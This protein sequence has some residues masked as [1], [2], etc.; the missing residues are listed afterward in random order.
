MGPRVACWDDLWRIVRREAED[1]PSW[2]S[3]AA[4]RGVFHEAIRQVREAG[5]IVAIERVVHWPGYRRRL[6]ERIRLWT[7]AE[8]PAKARARGSQRTAPVES[9]EWAVFVRYR[10]L[11]DRLKAED[12]AGMAVWA[13]KRLIRSPR[14]WEAPD[15]TA[16]VVFLDFERS[17][18][19]YWRV[20]ERALAS[21]RPVH[22]TL[23][24]ESDPAGAEVYCATEPIRERLI[25]LGL[26][27]TT[28]GPPAG[29]PAGL[30][31]VEQAL[32]RHRGEGEGESKG[33]RASTVS[34]AQGLAILGGPQGDGVSRLVAREVRALRRRGV[35]PE[36]ILVL[37]RHWSDEADL[38]LETL[39]AW[40]M[41]AHADTPRRLHAEPA[42][43]ALWLAV[44][45]PIE[46][47]ET[48]LIVRLLRHGQFCPGWPGTDRRTLATAASAIRATRVFR[49]REQ[50]LHGLDRA[51]NHAE[52]EKDEIQCERLRTARAVVDRLFTALL[53]LDEPRPWRLQVAEL[54][55]VSRA[56]G[57]GAGDE[58]ALDPLWD[59]LDDAADIWEKLGR[60]QVPWTWADFV[61]EVDAMAREV[62]VPALAPDPGSIPLATVDQAAGACAEY[63][64][65]ADL[66]EGTFPA[67]EEVE[68]FLALGPSDEPDRTT[69]LAF[70][71]EM[72]RFLRAVGSAGAVLTL[73]YPTTDLKG[74]E[75][76]RAGFLE[77]VLE[78]LTPAARAAC[79]A[80]YPRF[81]PALVDQPGLAGT[82]GDVRV[83]AAA[84]AGERG[85]PAELAR[86][87][88]D[89]A[90]RR[91]LDGTAA[92]L[93]VQQRRIRGTP[94]S[95]FEGLIRDGA[96]IFEVDTEFGPDYCFSASQLETYI[97]CPFQFFSKYV[98]KLT[99]IEQRDE[100]GEDYT[101]RGSQIH[102]ILDNFEKL[103]KQRTADQDLD[104]I[105]GIVTDS[106]LN[107]E[108]SYAT[109]L[110]MGLWEIERGRLIRTIAHYV[111]Q[112]RAYERDGELRST[113]HL[114]ELNFGEEDAPHPV[115]ELAHGGRKL[116]LGGRIDRIDL[117]ETPDGPRFR[118]IDY[119]SGSVPSSTEVKQG[120]MV[121][122]PLYA[123]AVQRLVLAD[124]GIG[125]FDLGY[126][127][128]K[129][130]GFRPISFDSWE[131]DQDTL[132]AHVLALVDQL[133][134][135]VF[136]VHSR[137]PGCENYC[138]FRGVCRVRQVR[139]AE[140]RR[141]LSLPALSIRTGRS[142]RKGKDQPSL[143]G[144]G[145]HSPAGA[146]T[147]SGS[148]S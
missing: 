70:A 90:H 34:A 116:K 101:E 40:G 65:L 89:P 53:F 129:N 75:L 113:P 110:D 43:S 22:V 58:S 98:L 131:E 140:K 50:L 133:R 119:K 55:K 111:L 146:A 132:V 66:A 74:Q 16:P 84:L 23:A 87:A 11:L 51:L 148:D 122:L 10:G 19:A 33:E 82:P 31:G 57:V 141:V 15:P 6:R 2:L 12:E 36:E 47:W 64:I 104:Q 118:I 83:R 7:A 48:E 130:E 69:Q 114:F 46:E 41:P 125:L 97:S 128:L 59:V 5:Q 112:R 120:E 95:E 79:H 28:V 138:E 145:S 92:A 32:F 139:A 44:S 72:L 62:H 73:V 88:R 1:G 18:E 14:F 106:V 71:R 30:K 109:D 39:T 8:L 27:E 105:A 117:V 99:P 85:E 61:A 142:R 35:A 94:F 25:E 121:Q 17:A 123:M 91:I 102:E 77:D 42:V 52:S 100:L 3:D 135:G 96:A 21:E 86:L 68:P 49:G 24:Y 29:R 4:A 144:A 78:L 134:R 60:G 137:K 56:L 127:S 26:V 76:L 81:H 107:R 103:L 13:S 45:I 143:D 126:W 108:P 54:R 9:A 136:V 67:R 38:V 93:F 37:F 147:S 115:L 20:L 63:V 124:D 80:S